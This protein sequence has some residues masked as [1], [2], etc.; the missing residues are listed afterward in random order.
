MIWHVALFNALLI[1]SCGY[2]LWCG[3]P[4]E[5]IVGGS[6]LLAALATML[7]Y[8]ELAVRFR[9]VETGLLATD[10]ML[11]AVLVLVALRADRGWPLVLAGLQVDTVGAHIVKAIDPRM[12]SVTYALMIAGW[13]YPMVILL[14]IG[15]WRHRCRLIR[16]GHDHS[17]YLRCAHTS[18]SA[19]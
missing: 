9:A 5:R 19:P 4:P 14:A 17:W 11:L 13:S 18:D 1:A 15:T 16:Y 6:L 2:A 3:G 10:L 7:S 12:I 8:S